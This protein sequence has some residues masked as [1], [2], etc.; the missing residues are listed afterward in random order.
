MYY[1][2]L[3]CI[4]MYHDV[5]WCIMMYDDVWWCIM[6]Y[7]D[8]LWCIMMYHDVSW[9]IMMYH[10]I[11]WYIMMYHDVSWC[12]MM[13]HDVLWCIMMYYDVLWCIM[14]YYVFLLSILL[15]P[16]SQETPSWRSGT[17]ENHLRCTLSGLENCLIFWTTT[18]WLVGQSGIRH[19]LDCFRIL[20]IIWISSDFLQTLRYHNFVV[21]FQCCPIVQDFMVHVPFNDVDNCYLRPA[22]V[23]AD[24]WLLSKVDRCFR[25]YP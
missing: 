7:Y 4:M 5:S 11:S 8:V 1:D 9:C 24:L 6:M 21:I 14:M 3:W 16:T 25:L 2:V 22:I 10:D 23:A 13:Y 18:P 12:M 19:I 17:M 15:K 20:N